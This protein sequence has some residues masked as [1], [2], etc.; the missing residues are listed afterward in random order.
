M[1]LAFT[2]HKY[3]SGMNASVKQVF[4]KHKDTLKAEYLIN[5]KTVTK[6]KFDTFLSGLKEIPETWFCAETTNGGI[7]GYDAKDKKGIVYQVRYYY[8]SGKSKNSITSKPSL[9]LE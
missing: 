5:D 3:I 2:G 4:Q 7:T 8:D 1:L 6:E 9:K